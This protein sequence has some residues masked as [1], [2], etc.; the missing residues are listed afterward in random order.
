MSAKKESPIY[1]V[2]AADIRAASRPSAKRRGS[3]FTTPTTLESIA[4]PERMDPGDAE[5]EAAGVAPGPRRQ[6]PRAPRVSDHRWLQLGAK[7]MM[8]ENNHAANYQANAAHFSLVTDLYGKQQ[9][10]T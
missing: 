8:I 6:R 4:N 10:V 3:G 7:V 5:E 1:S 2:S 9:D